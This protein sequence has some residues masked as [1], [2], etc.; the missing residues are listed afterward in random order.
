MD[1]DASSLNAPLSPA[2]AIPPIT[3]Q[4]V[5]LT[6]L[7]G[8]GLV[9]IATVLGLVALGAGEVPSVLHTA[10][11]FLVLIGVITIGAAISMRPDLWWI[12]AI[13]AAGARFRM[14]SNTMPGLSPEKGRRPVAIS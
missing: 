4:S 12:W 7:A 13:G 6:G 10:R 9:G 11:L 8:A 1:R 5:R 3:P 2:D 14:A